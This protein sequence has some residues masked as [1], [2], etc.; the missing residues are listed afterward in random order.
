LRPERRRTY[1]A[2]RLTRSIIFKWLN[3]A[4][5]PGQPLDITSS[6]IAHEPLAEAVT[7][8]ADALAGCFS[9]GVVAKL[10]LAELPAGAVIPEHRDVGPALALVHRCHVPILT[11]DRVEFWIDQRLHHFHAGIAYEIDNT[12]PH[13]VA[14]H[15]ITPRVHLICDVMGETEPGR[16][17][18]SARERCSTGSRRSSHGPIARG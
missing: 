18:T 15:G 4:W 11:N 6:V 14:N 17:A 12:R 7:A 8:A 1:Q 9:G 13:A 3:Q 5:M 16:P 10:M 2:H